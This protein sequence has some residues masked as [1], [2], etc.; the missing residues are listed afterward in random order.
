M[1]NHSIQ[2]LQQS[3]I[4]LLKQLIATP[5]FSKE[6]QDTASILKI[7]LEERGIEAKQF[8]YNI[9]AANRHFDASKPTLLLN[10]HHDTVKPNKGYTLDPFTPIV[11]EG[12]LFGLGSNDAGGPLVSLL[13]TFLH[14]YNRTDLK[15]N[16][17]FAASAEEE[18]SGRE[19][20]EILLPELPPIDCAIVGEPTLMQM[21]VAE[22]GL[23]VLDALSHGRAGHAAREE[24]ENA[25][26]KALKDIEWFSAY[27]FPKVSELLGPVKTSVTVIETDN[28]A[29]NVVP[30]QCR[31]VVDVRVNELYT[32]EEILNVIRKNIQSE[33]TPR[34]TRLRSTSIALE[35]PLVQ[36]GIKLGR[37]YYGSPT[38]SDK[39]LMPFQALK[40]GPGD[41]ARSHTADEFIYIEEIEDGI[42]L[43]I[44]LLN[45]VL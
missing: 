15:Y 21:A 24:G 41:S 11:K 9:W 31:F 19:G 10:S 12:K 27:R 44:D 28:K 42:A 3:A 2:E 22:R 32:F 13:A 38:T 1:N 33:V 37:T 25:I 43:Y 16:L 29:H 20:I 30:A 34:S 26:Y 14:F 35:H 39:A 17:L 18:I 23:M 4:E 5:S 6:E 36:S 7:F 40:M 45:Q 8:K